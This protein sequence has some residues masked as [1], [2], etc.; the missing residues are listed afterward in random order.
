MNG[1]FVF[2]K[3]IGTGGQGT[4]CIYKERSTGT[5]YAVKFDAIG[6]NTVLSEC[7]Y[8]KEFSHLLE[9]APKY[10]THTTIGGRR[11]LIMQYLD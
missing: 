4:V 7:L 8:L 9:R 5:D 1:E 2:K 3:V 6:Q 11:F 10:K